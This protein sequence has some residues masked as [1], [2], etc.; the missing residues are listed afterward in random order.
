VIGDADIS[1]SKLVADSL[2]SSLLSVTGDAE[3]LVSKHLDSSLGGVNLEEV[4][5]FENNASRSGN[6]KRQNNVKETNAF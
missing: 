1:V 3:L 6:V 5:R 2:G 4:L